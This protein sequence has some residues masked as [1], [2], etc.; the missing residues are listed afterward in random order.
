[1]EKD[2]VLNVFGKW[3][4]TVLKWRRQE[5]RSKH[6]Y[7]SHIVWVEFDFVLSDTCTVCIVCHYLPQQLLITG[8]RCHCGWN[9][10]TFYWQLWML[11]YMLCQVH[12]SSHAGCVSSV[13]LT[14]HDFSFHL[15]TCSEVVKGNGFCSLL[16][17]AWHL[18]LMCCAWMTACVS[19]CLNKQQRDF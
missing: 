4:D 2:A 13:N 18:V 10:L 14:L 6:E 3:T 15:R 5:E 16:L 9:A 7:R 19:V 17:S 12:T 11:F 1:V 8:K